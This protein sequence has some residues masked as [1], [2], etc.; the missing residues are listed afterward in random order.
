MCLTLKTVCFDQCACALSRGQSNTS[1]MGKPTCHDP[2][3]RAMSLRRLVIRVFV[4]L[5]MRT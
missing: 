5:R 3:I 1:H 2:N 4:S